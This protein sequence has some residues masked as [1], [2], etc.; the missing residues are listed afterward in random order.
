MIITINEK[1]EVISIFK[2]EGVEPDNLT[3]FE[4]ET[5]P[6]REASQVLCFNP[7]TMEFYSNDREPVDAEAIKEARARYAERRA[8]HEK[9]AAALKWLAD[10]DW[11]VNKH[12]LGEWADEDPRW[13]EYLAGR[14]QARKDYD[15]AEAVLNG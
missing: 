15:E 7:E 13:L 1:Q 14:E 2:G 9:K 8:A 6:E 5:I 4:V 10:N 12:T 3:S 11:K